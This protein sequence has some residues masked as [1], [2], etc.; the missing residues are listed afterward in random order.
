MNLILK[1]SQSEKDKY[2]RYHLYVESKIWHK[3]IFLQNRNRHI[4]IKTC[5]CQGRGG[6]E[7]DGL[8]VGGSGYKLLHLEWISNEVLLYSTGN[9]IQSLGREHDGR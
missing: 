6:K 3:C 2:H 9:Y 4:D 5:G 1:W 7:W 8:G